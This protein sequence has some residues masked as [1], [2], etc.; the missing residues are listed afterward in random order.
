MI[1]NTSVFISLCLISAF[2][3]CGE[4]RLKRFTPTKY[5]NNVSV[6]RNYYVK[7][8]LQI[9]DTLRYYLLE[10]KGFFYSKEYFDSTELI[11][12]TI[13]HNST[14]EKFI[15]FIITKNPTYRQLDPDKSTSW[16][17]NATS[18]IGVRRNKDLTLAWVG[19]NFSNAQNQFE[20]SR[21]IRD[22]YFT[23]LSDSDTTLNM[24]DVRFWKSNVW[25]KVGVD[26][27]SQK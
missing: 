14:L 15:V 5:L 26:N 2:I 6:P 21:I 8:S 9:L 7:D 22:A 10:H 16:Y 13:I 11:I 19:P 4:V 1:K 20:L 3:S 17:Y 27:R 23:E 12:D 24:N 18:F 25:R